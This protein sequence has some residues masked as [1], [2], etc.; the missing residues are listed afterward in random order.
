MRTIKFLL[1]LLISGS[2]FGQTPV[3]RM[4]YR[5]YSFWNQINVG[6]GA[7]A[8]TNTSAAFEILGSTR[9]FLL[10]R[11]T[12]A[13]RDAIGSPAN[14][15]MV[16]NTDIER[17]Q[18][19]YEGDWF[20]IVPSPEGAEPVTTV[21][22]RSGV[23]TAHSGDY[24]SDQ[25]TE[26]SINLFQTTARTRLALNAGT[27]I[28]YNSTTGAITSSLAIATQVQKTFFSGPASGADAIATFRTIAAGDLPDLS[29]TYQTPAA[30]AGLYV[31]LTRT[32]TINGTALDLSANRSFTTFNPT[33]S[34][35]A[36]GHVIRWNGSAWVNSAIQ[37]SDLPTSNT[38]SSIQLTTPSVLYNT[39]LSWSNT[40]GAWSATLSLISQ[41]AN[42]VLAAPN[43]SG[44]TPT[45]RSIVQADA[46]TLATINGNVNTQTGTT[47]TL[48]AS[49]NGK[50]VTISNASAITLTVPSGLGAGFNCLVVQLGAGQITFAASSTTL[51]NRQSFTKTAGQYAI[52][53][54]V[55]YASNTFITSG[56]MQ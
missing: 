51:N 46:P 11:L 40:A 18:Y 38:V 6:A 36:T 45:F 37:V 31:P 34:S 47:Y 44:G 2:A 12:T 10:P 9:G 5:H 30:A 55:A 24:N 53:T 27:G 20:N 56:D 54:V 19:F 29:G 8:V 43:G 49:D 42:T 4:A 39:P 23:V 21:F 48:V 17:L 16:V 50:V 28:S 15:L 33:V 1:V 22:G 26:G 3:Q 32:I 13:Q 7:D 52:A 35:V 25:V 41:T 14:Y